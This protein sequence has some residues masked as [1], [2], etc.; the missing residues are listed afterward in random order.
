M[1]NIMKKTVICGMQQVGIGVP[2]VYDAWRWYYD[3]F[4][5]DVKILDAEGVAERMLPYTGGK[6]QPRHAVLAY[7]LKGG[8]GLEIWEP[9]GRELSYL[10]NEARL[11]DYGIFSCKIKT[12]DID[13][14][15]SFLKQNNVDCLCEPCM[16]PN[17]LK[18]FFIKDPLGNIFD[19]EEDNYIFINSAKPFGGTNGII[20]G[21]SDMDKSIDY[22]KSI[23]GFDKIVFD[24]TEV[25]DDFKCLPNGADKVRRVRL[26]RTQKMAGPL[27]EIMGTS[28]IELVQ[29]MTSSCK[30]LYENRYWGDPGFIH[31]CFDIRNMATLEKEV[32]DYGYPF[33]CNSGADFVMGDADGW[34]SYI[35]DPDGTL[36]EFVE[37]RKV[38][39][40]KKLN[41]NLNLINKA[42]DKPLSR[43]ITK[44]L[45]FLKAKRP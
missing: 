45:R 5:F 26:D 4:G 29:N 9:K 8:G 31:V 18:H 21:V 34:F 36:I 22:Y 2:N 39:V 43:L 38:P 11:G 16:S 13:T 30:K 10:E 25:F 12:A 19:I 33:V 23:V 17:N 42:D 28:Y 44:S 20:L 3:I 15:F 40:I 7:N 24:E 37:T 14:A 35:E 32:A 6:P 27:S 1:A 41:I